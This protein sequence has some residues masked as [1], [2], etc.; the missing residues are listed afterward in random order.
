MLS[1]LGATSSLTSHPQS[2]CK[3]NFGSNCLR[4]P[5][6]LP[7]PTVGNSSHYPSQLSPEPIPSLGA[8]TTYRSLTAF[9]VEVP[10]LVS[11][12]LAQFNSS[13]ST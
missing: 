12:H 10:F 13:L 11:V 1:L 4:D 5:N 8:P 3:L 7:R 2:L 9:L 6:M